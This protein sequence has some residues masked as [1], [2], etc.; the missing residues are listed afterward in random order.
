MR[1]RST[2]MVVLAVAV[3][4]AITA[5]VALAGPAGR[6][7]PSANGNSQ[8]V[9]AVLSPKKLGKKHFT[10][11]AL[12]V[13]T[14]LFSSTASDGVPVP[15][16]N[17]VIDF[18]KN[19]KIFTKGVPTCKASQ[20][21]N[22]STEIA[23]RVC[24]RSIIGKGTARALL[25]VGANVYPVKQ[26]VTAFNGVPK[27]RK[28]VILLHTYGTTPV[29]TTLVLIGTVRNYYKEG[30]GPRLNVEVPL[31]A[32]G[33]GA[34]TYFNVK[35]DHKYKYKGKRVSYI[36]GKCPKSKKLKVRSVFTF[37]D[38]ETSNPVY[39]DRCKQNPKK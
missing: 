38:G 7:V 17:V 4:A 11:A 27:G 12:E 16:T 2:L 33:E 35:V 21:Q 34:L 8:A 24:R 9:G 36:S 3:A 22:T 15:T 29:Q 26:T 28:P 31:I 13:T 37:L 25:R 32:G 23:R 19:T 10:P 20:L 39:K 18:D 14:K 30:Y 6:Y 1:K 5:S